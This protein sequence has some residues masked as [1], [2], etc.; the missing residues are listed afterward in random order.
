MSGP[1]FRPAI[2]EGDNR[3]RQICGSCGFIDYENPKIVAGAVVTERGPNGEELFLLCRRAIEPRRGFWTLPA[4]FL[5]AKESP[6]EGARREAF[7]EACAEI[8]LEGLLGIYSVP[9]ISQVMIFFRARL[10]GGSFACGS[11]STDVRLFRWEEIPWGE[12]AFDSVPWALE[13][14]REGTRSGLWAAALYPALAKP[15]SDGSA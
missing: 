14:W 15:E 10:A 8:Q 2:P 12:L 13:R 6:D 9:R 3:E 4:G 7:E 1:H 11:E 5:E